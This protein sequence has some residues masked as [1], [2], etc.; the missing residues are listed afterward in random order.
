M[1]K[2][3]L[4][5]PDGNQRILDAGVTAADVANA[6]STSL[7]KKAISAQIDGAHYDLQWPLM[8]EMRKFPST[9][10][11]TKHQHLN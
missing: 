7:G 10:W 9:Q 5:F 6:I 8:R 2:V 1:A 3:T 4:T 11:Q